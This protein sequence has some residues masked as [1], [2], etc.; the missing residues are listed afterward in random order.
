MIASIT[1]LLLFILCYIIGMMLTYVLP[2]HLSSLQKTLLSPTIGLSLIV[3][4]FY[5]VN[6]LGYTINEAAIPIT[7][8]FLLI[9]FLVLFKN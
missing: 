9:S 8:I 1:S 3:I 4:V 7:L 6:V 5:F 2:N